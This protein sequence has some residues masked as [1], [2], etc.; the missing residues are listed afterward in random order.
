MTKKAKHKTPRKPRPRRPAPAAGGPAIP[1]TATFTATALAPLLN[2]YSAT[3]G[4]T[5]SITVPHASTF[6]ELREVTVS[7]QLLPKQ[8]VT[9]DLKTGK[10]TASQLGDGTYK[11]SPDGDI[12]LCLGT[13]PGQVHIA[14]EVQ[15]AKAWATT[16]NKSV[17]QP[18]VVTGFFRSL[19]EH[20][21]FRS[22][23]DAHIF[24][25]HP[26]RAVTIGGQVIPFDVDIPDQASIHTWTSPHD[27]NVQDGQIQVVANAAK[28]TL[29]FSHMDG[30]DENYVSVSGTVTNI[31]IPD[32]QTGP[33]TFTFTSTDIGHP[34]EGV[35]LHATRAIKQLGQIG[36][37]GTVN[38]IAL[39][40]IDLTKAAQNKYVISLLA[41]DIQLGLR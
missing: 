29:T 33:A 30:Q 15:N 21:G 12:H 23:D 22:N 10:R 28:D 31:Q 7:G 14:C 11:P 5:K 3:P 26:V 16:F 25:V 1:G 20:P 40:N 13:K 17:G 35:C 39:R 38:M 8:I 24:E 18:I 34:L 41:I 2:D 36:A 19:F 6:E 32:V 4:A 27:L 37:G 9:L